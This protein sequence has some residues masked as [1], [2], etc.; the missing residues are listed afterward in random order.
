MKDGGKLGKKDTV[1]KEYM[2]N[3]TVFADAFNQ[4]LYHGRQVIKPE[5]LKELDGSE[6]AVPYGSENASVPEQRYRDVLKTMMT[7]GNMAY[8]IL[9][10]ENQSDIHYAIPVKNGLYD[11]LQLAHQVTETAKSHKR[12]GKK[13][14]GMESS[15]FS[16]DEYL[17]GFYKT[18]RLLPVVTLTIFYSAEEWDGPLTL[19]EM[20]ADLDDAVMQHVPDYRVNLIA[21]GNMTEEEIGEFQS[22]LK[23]VLLYIKYSKDKEKLQEVTQKHKNFRSLDRQAAE[24]IRVT[25]NSKLK[26]GQKEEVVNVCLALEEMKMDSERKGERKGEIKGSVETYQEVDF[27]LQ[28]TVQRVAKKFNLS[29]QESEEEVRKYWK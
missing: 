10:I 27:S 7:D 24:V 21:P 2:R 17:S 8:C 12:K 23:E 11:F 22:S 28:D 15:S 6:I 29:L 18:D 3:P 9:G 14:A 25:T 1:T 19:R 16:Q 26:Y 13:N 20:Y 4:Y 5:N